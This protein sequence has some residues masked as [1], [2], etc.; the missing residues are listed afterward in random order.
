MTLPKTSLGTA[1]TFKVYLPAGYVSTGRYPVLYLFRGTVDEWLNPTQDESRQGRNA[2]SI[3][4]GL[5]KQ[6]A[7]GEMILV[8]VGLGSDDGQWPGILSNWV[9]PALAPGVGTGRFASYLFDDVIPAVDSRYRTVA[10]GQGRALDGFSLGGWAALQAATLQPASFASVGAYDGT[11]PLAGSRDQVKAD[12]GVIKA[13][14]MD[15]VFGRPRQAGAVAATSPANRIWQGESSQWKRLCWLIEYGPEAA[16]PSDANFYRGESLVQI[17][18]AHGGENQLGVRP[19]GR[20][21]WWTAD[22]H[23]KTS[24]PRHWEALRGSR[25]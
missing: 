2:V 21:N 13:P 12:D 7:V 18:A 6:K 3:Y 5:A 4:E 20:H 8:F 23:L 24:L 1:K 17:L 22:E 9:S 10:N 16:E 25:K 15:A 19:E 11:F 14:F